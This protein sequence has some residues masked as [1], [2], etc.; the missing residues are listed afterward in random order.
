MQY[1]A[2]YVGLDVSLEETKAC[3]VDEAGKVIWRG[4]C[5]ST[6]E[7]IE[8]LVRKH[9]PNAVRIGFETG[10]LSVWHFHELKKRG[11][12]VICIDARH[13]KA[14]LSVQINKTDAND[15][16]GI[17][18][19]V[20]V[21]WYREVLVKSMDTY[22]VRSMIIARSQL[23][24]TG[25]NIKNTVRGLLKTFGILLP[26][27]SPRRYVMTVRQ[28]I[29]GNPILLTIME[30]MLIA[31]AT[32]NEQIEVFDAALRRKA[33]A[34]TVAQRLMTAPGVGVI[35]ALS[36]IH[37]IED[38]ARFGRSRTVG[39]YLGLTPKRDQSGERDVIGKISRAGDRTM[40][41]LLYEAAGVLLHRCSRPCAL[42]EWG[43]GLKERLG[44][45]WATVAVARKLAVILHRMW[46]DGTAFQWQEPRLLAA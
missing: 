3:V 7:K 33:R 10:I 28:A 46:R 13:A 24:N 31:L 4:K 29:D 44:N 25:T 14:A 40:R 26:K 15:A 20:R 23:V 45:K 35:V 43:Q 42:K 5:D 2:E 17:A 12:P 22:A 19:I 21:G 34:D 30:P 6:P 16:L 32:I 36:F 39:A 1:Y 27:G 9:A 41:G 8:Q 37:T 11:L 38:P 18:Q